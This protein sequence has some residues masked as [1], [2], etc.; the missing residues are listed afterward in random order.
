MTN[1]QETRLLVTLS[2]FYHL[3]EISLPTL[4]STASKTL[5]A[6]LSNDR[7]TLM[8]VIDNMDQIVFEDF[9]KKRSR[10]L[11]EVMENGILRGGVDWLNAGKPTGESAS[12]GRAISVMTMRKESPA[13]FPGQRKKVGASKR[14]REEYR[15]KANIQRSELICT[16]QYSYSLKHI[17]KSAIQ[18][19]QTPMYS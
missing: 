9:I 7:E 19:R 12:T 3:K 2:K 6:D 15:G 1:K 10:A 11:V 13:G 14:G 16:K 5:D 18:S 8:Q 17:Q 4:L